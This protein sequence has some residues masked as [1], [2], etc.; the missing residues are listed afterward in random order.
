MTT[1]IGVVVVE[2]PYGSTRE[3]FIMAELYPDD[4]SAE[5]SDPAEFDIW[6]MQ[7][8]N[9]GFGNGEKPNKKRM[10]AC[11]KHLDSIRRCA[12]MGSPEILISLHP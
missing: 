5:C 12:Q 8:P 6:Y 10:G 1:S 11:M 3:E 7:T 2:I 9:Y 4:C